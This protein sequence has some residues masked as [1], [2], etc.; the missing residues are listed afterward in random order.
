MRLF[1]CEN[2][3]RGNKSPTTDL[4]P[5]LTVY[6]EVQGCHPWKVTSCAVVTT[7]HQGDSW[8]RFERPVGPPAT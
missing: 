7:A 3:A 4:F 1:T 8:V 2:E 6:T 5:V